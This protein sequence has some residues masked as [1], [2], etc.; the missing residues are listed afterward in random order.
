MIR[1]FLIFLLG[2]IGHFFVLF[3]AISRTLYRGVLQYCTLNSPH[4]PPHVTLLLSGL[5]DWDEFCTYMMIDL[6][7]KTRLRNER[8]VP[9]LVAPRLLDTPHR[10]PIRAIQLLTNPA[11]IMTV[12]EEGVVCFWTMKFTLNKCVRG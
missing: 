12:S 4:S 5:V 2:G 1:G 9:L 7:E 11:R 3:A 8:D 10:A 6:E